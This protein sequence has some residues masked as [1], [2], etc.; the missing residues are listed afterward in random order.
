[1]QREALIHLTA[2]IASAYVASNRLE[3]D[4]VGRL[5]SD[6]HGALANLGQSAP[7]DLP[8]PIVS[9]RSSIKKDHLVCLVCGEKMK[10]LKRHL[11]VQHDMEPDEYRVAYNLSEDYPMIAREY[12]DQRREVALSIGL[13]KQPAQRR[14][15]K[16]RSSGGKS[17]SKSK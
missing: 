15:R 13:G 7:V 10:M 5:V 9:V 6:V 8:E 4:E 17:N 3:I 16:S 1:M 2:E 14:G 12:A 11:R